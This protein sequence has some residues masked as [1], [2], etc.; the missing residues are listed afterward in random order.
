VYPWP[1]YEKQ[2]HFGHLYEV[3]EKNT[4][5][6]ESKVPFPY[7]NSGGY[8]GRAGYMR[9]MI[10]EVMDDV[11]KGHLVGGGTVGDADDQRWL[12][13]HW[14]RHHN[15]VAIDV[16]A[17]IF[18]SLHR[19]QLPLSLGR[20]YASLIHPLNI[21]EVGTPLSHEIQPIIN[22]SAQRSS[23][24]AWMKLG[25][26]AVTPLVLHGNGHGKRMF[27]IISCK[28]GLHC[29]WNNSPMVDEEKKERDPV[30]QAEL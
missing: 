9:S 19:L 21:S 15:E 2:P 22:N 11:R 12:Q 6:D 29:E 27:R 28:L 23:I 24:N 1:L 3:Q 18:L 10:V 25:E 4:T 17:E 30:N 26:T 16:M 7:P 14:L 5:I 13:R 8:I 20:T